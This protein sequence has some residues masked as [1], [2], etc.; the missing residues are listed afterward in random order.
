ML[1]SADLGVLQAVRRHDLLSCL[2]T[3]LDMRDQD[4]ALRRTNLRVADDE[5]LARAPITFLPRVLGKVEG[6]H[7]T[8]DRLLLLA[9]G[10]LLQVH[11]RLEHCLACSCARQPGGLKAL[12][13]PLGLGA[14]LVGLRVQ[15]EHRLAALSHADLQRQCQVLQIQSSRWVRSGRHAGSL[16]L[17]V[18][19]DRVHPR[20]DGGKAH[21]PRAG[22]VPRHPLNLPTN[23]VLG[24][25]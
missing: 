17:L 20:R 22:Q 13:L 19:C 25:A 10:K 16:G 5:P 7:H 9:H 21:L 4:T 2:H 8:C 24:T 18:K 3:H 11:V 6:V 23:V 15:R 14:V 12:H 1:R